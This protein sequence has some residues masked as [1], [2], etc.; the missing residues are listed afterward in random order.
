M[1]FD[2]RQLIRSI[3]KWSSVNDQGHSPMST[4]TTMAA[5]SLKIRE[6]MQVGRAHG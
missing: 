1:F 3:I 6:A 5:I 2:F 4:L